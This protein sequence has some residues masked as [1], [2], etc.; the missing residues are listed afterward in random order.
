L[1]IRV[2]TALV[3]LVGTTWHSQLGAENIAQAFAKGGVTGLGARAMGM[4]GAF[5][6]QADDSSAVYWNPAGL[7]QIYRPE[8][9]FM[10]GALMNGKVLNS[11]LAVL[12][13]FADQMVAGLATELRSHTSGN[14]A[15]HGVYYATFA[16][17][18][19]IEK[20]IAFGVNIKYYSA[21]SAK[22][23]NYRA[24]GW[25]TDLGFLLKLPL[26]WLER[27]GKE[28]DLGL[29]IEDLSTHLQWDTGAEERIPTR[30]RAGFAYRMNDNL[31][32]EFDA[33]S[34]EGLGGGT[35]PSAPAS[36]TPTPQPG[37]VSHKDT[38][39]RSGIEGWFF[40]DKLGMRLGYSG[41]S[42]LPGRYT[43]GISYRAH[44]WN[45]DYAFLGHS[46]HLGASHRVSAAL[47]FGKALGKRVSF[48]PQ[49]LRYEIEEGVLY[50]VWDKP[51]GIN[52]SGYNVYVTQIPGRNYTKI[53][54]DLVKDNYTPLH[55]FRENQ[56]YYF[57]V[58]SVLADNITESEFS[59]EL[60]VVYSEA[61]RAPEIIAPSEEEAVIYMA[62]APMAGVDGFNVYFSEFKDGDYE[63]I[64]DSVVKTP[65]YVVR[66][67]RLHLKIGKKYFI[68]VTAIKGGMEGPPTN[69]KQQIAIPASSI[70]K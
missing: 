53:K 47:R 63:R 20:T 41:F 49:G 65:E 55:G 7:V 30:V 31:T 35:A 39:M 17:P 45:L 42:T 50:L 60:E 10:G 66:G 70:G 36:G 37:V 69:P 40:Q 12:Q 21:R 28:I 5:V 15:K 48:V 22:I 14:K 32:M 18:L 3:I 27:Y 19:N 1:K 25:G 38:K 33:E 58:T 24:G 4:G 8:I 11:Y 2:L 57:V 16:M 23:S 44:S 46:Q 68:K 29:M 43:A 59:K 56:K 13:P 64:N 6:A 67:D 61:L 9:H 62:W 51:R 54:T 52:L 26:P 34:F